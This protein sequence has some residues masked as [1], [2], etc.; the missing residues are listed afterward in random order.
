M[1]LEPRLSHPGGAWNH[2]GHLDL[3]S[4]RAGST[5]YIRAQK[6]GGMLTIGDTH[7]YQGDGELTGTGVGIDTT[8]TVKI[9]RG[10]DFPNGGVVVETAEN[11]LPP[12]SPPTG[13]AP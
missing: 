3:N 8:V 7:A 6:Y 4:I 5:V 9:E 10:P 2:G 13:R 11:G 12:A 1:Q